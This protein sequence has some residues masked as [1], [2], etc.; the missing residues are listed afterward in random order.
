L[1]G[2]AFFAAAGPLVA[3]L[4]TTLEEPDFFATFVA[5]GFGLPTFF[6]G[7][8]FF[9]ISLTWPLKSVGASKIT[10]KSQEPFP[11]NTGLGSPA[12]R[13][14]FENVPMVQKTIQHGGDGGTITEQLSPVFNG[15]VRCNQR[16]GSLVAS[17]DDFQQFLGG[18]QRQLAHSQVIDDEKRRSGSSST[19][20]LRLRANPSPSLLRES[21]LR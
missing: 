13:A 19:C 6:A 3:V 5:A 16:A 12:A 8:C 17:H 2:A 10:Y 18:G 14:A 4:G 20:C 11:T 7:T 9:A 15:S 1:D 21:F